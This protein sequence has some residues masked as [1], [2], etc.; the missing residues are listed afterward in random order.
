MFTV[1]T[2]AILDKRLSNMN[3][4]CTQLL[5]EWKAGRAMKASIKVGRI[6]Y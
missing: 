2:I 6:G 1:Y 5:E 4:S 3:A